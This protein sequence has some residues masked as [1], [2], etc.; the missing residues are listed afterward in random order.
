MVFRALGAATLSYLLVLAKDHDAGVPV[1]PGVRMH[2]NAL[3]RK[4]VESDFVVLSTPLHRFFTYSL[5][6]SSHSFPPQGG[7]FLFVP[8]LV[9]QA[10]RHLRHRFIP[11]VQAKDR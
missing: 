4:L 8:S 1:N 3:V 5:S 11:A 10:D 2:S 9:I 7:I 6:L